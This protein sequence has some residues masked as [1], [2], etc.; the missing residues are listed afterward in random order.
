M[1]YSIE[2]LENFT[3]D[4]I[5]QILLYF[6]HQLLDTKT[7]R[8]NAI[9]LSFNNNLLVNEDRPYV[10]N[11]EFNKLYNATDEQLRILAQERG[12]I[13]PN[14]REGKK[15]AMIKYI[16][17]NVNKTIIPVISNIPSN[18]AQSMILYNMNGNLYL[19]GTGTFNLRDKLKSLGGVWNPSFKCWSFP[20]TSRDSLLN[21]IPSSLTTTKLAVSIPSMIPNVTE[22]PSK[23]P[24]NLQIYQYNNHVLLCGSRTYELQDQ[25]KALNG[26]FDSLVKCWS[27]PPEQANNVLGLYNSA[28]REDYLEAERIQEQRNLTRQQNQ[29][30]VRLQALEEVQRQSRL[31]V[32]EQDTIFIKHID[33]LSNAE[34]N[35]NLEDLERADINELRSLWDSKIQILNYVASKE[36]IVTYIGDIKPPNLALEYKVNGWS[37]IPLGASVRR[38]DYKKY[39]VIVFG[40]D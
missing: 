37:Y 18:I 31:Q 17:D 36:A 12:F 10:M 35:G 6:N 29:E 4:Q 21:L 16:I 15:I 14:I 1:S 7:N 2:I 5:K 13:F 3:D 40:T 26:K 8:L 20:L 33:R 25:L 9:I 22:I 27:F 39:N 30:R 38:I 24:N 11:P 23:I 28:I 32:P 34:R 19:C